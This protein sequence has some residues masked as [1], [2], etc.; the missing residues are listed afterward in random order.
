M[1]LPDLSRLSLGHAGAE[2]DVGMKDNERRNWMRNESARMNALGRWGKRAEQRDENQSERVSPQREIVGPIDKDA[3]RA[4]MERARAEEAARNQE[5]EEEERKKR[6]KER[7]IEQ[8][9]KQ[10]DEQYEKDLEAAAKRR[11][12]ASAAVVAEYKAAEDKAMDDQYD[13][14]LRIK[15]L[16]NLQKRD[17]PKGSEERAR[18]KTAFA[19]QVKESRETLDELLDVLE[20]TRAT[21]LR[22]IELD[23][24]A[25]E[26]LAWEKRG[27]AREAA[28]ER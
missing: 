3:R 20:Q 16:Y 6:K 12:E 9:H 5:E 8:A 2:A 15:E 17:T 21:K 11:D 22:S 28:Y 13:M 18:L 7:L 14:K 26:R 19:Q 10:A 27:S 24:G 23:Y 1:L 4:R 25:D